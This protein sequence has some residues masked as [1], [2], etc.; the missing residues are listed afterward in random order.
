MMVPHGFF[1][2][3]RSCSHFIGAFINFFILLGLL[4]LNLRVLFNILNFYRRIIKMIFFRIKNLRCF[5]IFLNKYRSHFLFLRYILSFLIYTRNSTLFEYLVL[6]VFIKKSINTRN[7]K[8]QTSKSYGANYK[9]GKIPVGFPF[10]PYNNNALL[11][12]LGHLEYL[13]AFLFVRVW[14]LTSFG[15]RFSLNKPASEHSFNFIPCVRGC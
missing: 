1:I 9:I 8:F 13:L 7:H 11:H 10:L 5:S 3:L 4:R 15:R 12:K 6:R 14:F 2:T